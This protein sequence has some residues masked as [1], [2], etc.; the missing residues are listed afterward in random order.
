[1]DLK[2]K[3]SE[4]NYLL[5]KDR[6]E[7]K[8]QTDKDN[9]D[10]KMK[11]EENKHLRE[12]EKIKIEKT[13]IELEGKEKIAKIE[14]ETK[15]K[16]IENKKEIEQMKLK[17][18]EKEEETKLK[19]SQIQ[20]D[21]QTKLKECDVKKE[22]NNYKIEDLNANKE[23][24]LKELDGKMK[25]KYEEVQFKAKII[26]ESKDL[27]KNQKFAIFNKMLDM[28]NGTPAQP[29]SPPAYPNPYGPMQV[30]GGVP[31]PYYPYAQYPQSQPIVN[32][33]MPGYS[34]YN[35]Y[36]PNPQMPP[37]PA[38]PMVMVTPGQ[39][40]SNINNQYMY[41]QGG[42]PNPNAFA[43][44]N[45]MYAKPMENNIVANPQNEQQQIY[46]KEPIN[47]NQDNIS[48][49]YQGPPARLS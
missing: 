24:K 48:R 1:M 30:Y 44:Q 26:E 17:A 39:Q 27:D 32:P 45:M 47:N 29:I 2:E 4:R 43:P 28:K 18:K 5:E 31:Q 23:V 3:E 41:P 13:K 12:F 9:H 16:E 15:Q 35:P 40:N 7:K 6:I 42:N 49:S 10:L 46:Q 8:A 37:Q 14:E 11:K 38:N 19:M 25:E 22:E 21:S 33:Y 34:V 36:M 20:A